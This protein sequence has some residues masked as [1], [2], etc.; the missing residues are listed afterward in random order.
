MSL[1]SVSKYLPIIEKNTIFV[2]F[3]EEFY[4]KSIRK[5]SKKTRIQFLNYL[6]GFLAGNVSKYFSHSFL[7]QELNFLSEE[8]DIKLNDTYTPNSTLHVLSQP[9]DTGGH[10]KLVEQWIKNFGFQDNHSAV[11]INHKC[12]IPN[13]FKDIITQNGTIFQLK[14]GDFETKAKQLALVASNFE[15]VILHIHPFEILANLAFANS[16]F[17]RPVGFLNHADHMFSCGYAVSDVVFELSTEG[18]EFS[19][20]YRGIQNTHVVHIPIEEKNSTLSKEN[21]KK[22]LN[23]A[24][25]KI[26]IL[27]IASEYK[28]GDGND[29]I[30]MAKRIIALKENIEFILIGPSIISSPIW[31]KAKEESNSRI[32]PVGMKPRDEL[33]Y[34][35]KASDIFIESFPFGSY[36]VFLDVSSYGINIL[37][38]KNPNFNLDVVLNH[39]S[40]CQ[41]IDEIVKKVEIILNHPKTEE[42]VISLS[43]NYPSTWIKKCQS[44][45]VDEM[46]HHKSMN[47]NNAQLS[48]DFYANHISSVMKSSIPLGTSYKKLPILIKIVLMSK[49][50]KLGLVPRKKLKAISKTLF[51]F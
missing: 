21:A 10:T 34:Y 40:Q 19:K 16:H 37:R 42:F 39:P 28:Y 29:F 35:I 44:I 45:I 8:I 23:I 32:N 18:K 4:K 36:T 6:A 51:P 41:N 2:D 1:N 3:C 5:K 48:T 27:S 9:Y 14:K 11:I 47:L 46:K 24:D 43:D 12:A 38:L 49:L 26:I 25:N 30:D 33:K 17:T 15:K 22:Y 7:E 20:T 50:I 13:S 31:K